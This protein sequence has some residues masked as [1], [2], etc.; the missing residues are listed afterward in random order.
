MSLQNLLRNDPNKKN[1]NIFVNDIAIDGVFSTDNI[2]ISGNTISSTDTNGK[3]ILDPDGTGMVDIKSNLEVDGIT[4]ISANL[5]AQFREIS[6]IGGGSGTFPLIKFNDSTKSIKYDEAVGMNFNI[7]GSRKYEWFVNTI[8]KLE[9][10]SVGSLNISDGSLQLNDVVRI[11]NDGAGVLLDLKLTQTDARLDFDATLLDRGLRYIGGSGMVL[12]AP[13]GENFVVSIN[14]NNVLEVLGNGG[15]VAGFLNTGAGTSLVIDGSGN[16]IIDSSS[17]RFKE[18]IVTLSTTFSEK[19]FDVTP[20]SYSRIND[21]ES[22]IEVGFTAEQL[23][24]AGLQA[25]VTYDNENLP[26]SIKYDRLVIPLISELKKLKI[27]HEALV[28]DQQSL[29]SE[30]DALKLEYETFKTEWATYKI[31]HPL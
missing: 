28:I 31:A 21:E 9:L 17:A 27:S 15:L 12:E 7:P 2:A 8:K 4:A 29:E 14:S 24:S 11:A 6:L 18:N 5:E 26:Y 10:S 19:L 20:V 30:H 22:K 1:L 3:I 23:D 25:Y 13:V 16:I